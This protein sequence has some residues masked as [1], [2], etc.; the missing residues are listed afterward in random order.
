MLNHKNNTNCYVK[1]K[2]FI[3]FAGD[4]LTECPPIGLAFC[5]AFCP[6]EVFNPVTCEPLWQLQT[7][8]YKSRAEFNNAITHSY[9]NMCYDSLTLIAR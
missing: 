5:L 7:L 9:F 4:A 6:P 1:K 3:Y 8:L 2:N